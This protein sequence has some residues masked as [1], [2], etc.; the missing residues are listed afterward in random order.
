MLQSVR[1]SR[2]DKFRG[3]IDK[4]AGKV[5]V[6]VGKWTASRKFVAMG[7]AAHAR[8]VARTRK[9]RLKRWVF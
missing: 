7:R 2:E 8:G 9:G 3:A 5:L 6:G 1:S 4:F